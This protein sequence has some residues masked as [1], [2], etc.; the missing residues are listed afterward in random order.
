LHFSIAGCFPARSV[1][2]WDIV[3][4]LRTGQQATVPLGKDVVTK[5]RIIESRRARL[6]NPARVPSE[7]YV[8]LTKHVPMEPSN[9]VVPPEN[10]NAERSPAPPTRTFTGRTCPETAYLRR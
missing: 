9:M 1:Q 2:K 4:V 3:P 7:L 6:T 5:S 8:Q 10:S